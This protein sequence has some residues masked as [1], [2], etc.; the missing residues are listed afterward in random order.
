MR[1]QSAIFD[2]AEE[3]LLFLS[4]REPVVTESREANTGGLLG[5][6]DVLT[7]GTCDRQLSAYETMQEYVKSNTP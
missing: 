4:N 2:S 5:M 6:L 7:G 1:D 3:M